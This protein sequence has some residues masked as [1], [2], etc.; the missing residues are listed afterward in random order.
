VSDDEPQDD[1]S[2]GDAEEP[3]YEVSHNVSLYLRRPDQL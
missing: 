3:R 2:E 1:Q